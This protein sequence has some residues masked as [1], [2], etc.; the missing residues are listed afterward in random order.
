MDGDGGLGGAPG[1]TNSVRKVDNE[2]AKTM[3][4]MYIFQGLCA[5][6]DMQDFR[7]IVDYMRTQYYNKHLEDQVGYQ[8]SIITRFAR[9]VRINC[10]GDELISGFPHLQP[11]KARYDDFF[12]LESAPERAIGELPVPSVLGFPLL[13]RRIGSGLPWK[14]RHCHDNKVLTYGHNMFTMIVSPAQWT[15]FTGTLM[16]ARKDTKY[17][18]EAHMAALLGYC[19]GLGGATTVHPT[20]E[21]DPSRDINKEML[22]QFEDR[23]KTILRKA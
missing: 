18:H 7:H 5:H 1:P 20:A 16:A 12:N 22:L 23:E 8:N 10:Q 14:Y 15:T 11:F 2:L 9:G 19:R 17:L 21:G 3:K 13:V 6:L 4:S